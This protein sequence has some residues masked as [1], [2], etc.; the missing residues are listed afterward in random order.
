MIMNFS[1][2]I[3]LSNFCLKIVLL[4]RLYFHSEI[5]NTIQDRKNY[6]IRILSKFQNFIKFIF[7]TTLTLACQTTDSN[8]NT[9][10]RKIA[11]PS[12]REFVKI[13]EQNFVGKW[14]AQFIDT[15][16]RIINLELNVTSLGDNKF[17]CELIVPNETIQIFKSSYQFGRNILEAEGFTMSPIMGGFADITL[18][19][20]PILKKE[21]NIKFVL[22]PDP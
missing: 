1:K 17:N 21:P 19:K 14:Q 16:S 20:H 9:S 15:D 13:I 22:V 5:L 6:L 7:L 10:N 8:S 11:N 18:P 3:I 2:S 12:S 4:A